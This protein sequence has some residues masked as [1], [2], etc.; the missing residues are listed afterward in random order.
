MMGENKTSEMK[1]SVVLN[2]VEYPF[3]LYDA[4]C[5]AAFER[6]MDL[7]REEQPK[8]DVLTEVIAGEVGAAR[9]F[10][11]ELFGAGTALAVLGEVDNLNDAL[12]A[13]GAVKQAVAE[14]VAAM[15][16]RM[17]AYRK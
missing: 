9:R 1:K 12:D 6:A 4:K 5:A 11:D 17:A 2:G 3:D 8:S 13:V 14:Q 10:L 16:E 15:Q 7:L